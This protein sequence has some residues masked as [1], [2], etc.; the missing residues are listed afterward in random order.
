MLTGHKITTYS[1]TLDNGDTGWFISINIFVLFFHFVWYI[2]LCLAV[3]NCANLVE[4][5]TFSSEKPEWMMTCEI[6]SILGKRDT[7]TKCIASHYIC[8][9]NICILRVATAQ[10]R[11][12]DK[13][14]IGRKLYATVKRHWI[15]SDK[16]HWLCTRDVSRIDSVICFNFAKQLHQ[17]AFQ[18]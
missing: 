7:F 18:C 15:Y 5:I 6:H 3:S 16:C 4:S 1:F 14:R 10:A 12:H 17:N 9:D 2:P 8:H 13:L 11:Q